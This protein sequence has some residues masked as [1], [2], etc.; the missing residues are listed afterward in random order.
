MSPV[1]TRNGMFPRHERAASR[2]I[3]VLEVRMEKDVMISVKGT[4]TYT[5]ADA[6]T[7]ELMTAGQL[8]KDSSGYTLT[9]QESELT[10]LND[11]LTTI[12]VE[13]PQVTLL[14]VGEVN[15]QMIFQEGRRH[16]S[17]YETPFGAMSIG[18][19]TRRLS[20]SLS[21]QG[22]E[23]IIDYDVEIDNVL[24]GRNTF[25]IGVRPAVKQE[26]ERGAREEKTQ[27]GKRRTEDRP[28]AD[29]PSLQ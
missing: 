6:D 27:K 25:R 19:N 29:A 18:I 22:G 5:D 16:L 24:A 4:Q 15:T 20:A 11:T 9:Y 17:M 3:Y 28:A 2:K 12:R 1:K 13:G 21:D 8:E 14:R 10:G 7:L 23:I 26:T